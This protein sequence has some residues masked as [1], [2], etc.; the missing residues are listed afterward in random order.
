VSAALVTTVLFYSQIW[1]N[2][3]LPDS[4]YYCRR[5]AFRAHSWRIRYHTNRFHDFRSRRMCIEEQHI[6]C[7]YT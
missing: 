1:R 7:F 3:L 4:S 5:Y 2:A 6:H